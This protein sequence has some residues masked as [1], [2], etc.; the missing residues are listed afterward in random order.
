MAKK[1]FLRR[2]F[3]RFSTSNPQQWFVDWVSGGTGASAGI[4]I[5]EDKAMGY[6]PFWAAV[7]V[8]SGAIATLPLL[9]YRKTADG[10][11]R[12]EDHPVYRL[13]HD[14]PNP[15]MTAMTFIETRQAHALVYGNGYAEI[16]RDGAGRPVALWPL[17]PDKTTKKITT[18]KVKFP[19]YE[20]TLSD[21]STVQLPDYN[22]L[23]IP[24]LGF[25]GFTGYPVAQYHKEAIG[26]GMAT[27]KFGAAFFGNNAVPGGVLEMPGEITAEQAKLIQKQWDELHKGLEQSHRIAILEAGT[28]YKQMGV[29]PNDAQCLE[30]QKFSVDDVARIFCIPPHKIA[31]LERATFSNI[32][33]Q[34]LDFLTQ[35][36]VYWMRKWESE[37][38]NKLTLESEKGR[39]LA[40]FLPEVFLRG[41]TTSRYAAYAT[42]R[43]WGWLS[44]NDIRRLENL[45]SIGPDGDIYLEPLN[46]KPAGEPPPAPPE[47]P[48]PS[49]D[50]TGDEDEGDVAQNA[51]KIS[52]LTT[53]MTRLLR[54]EANAVSKLAKENG[55]L[56]AWYAVFETEIRRTLEK[57][58]SPLK[59]AELAQ[60]HVQNS[61]K[62]LENQPKEAIP[63]LVDAWDMTRASELLDHCLE[64]LHH[65]RANAK[66]NPRSSH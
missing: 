44:I 38:N 48:K 2:L 63:G 12:A 1:S 32:E 29:N 39:Y 53:A 54:R 24:G 61:Q 27:K 40:E 35:T 6:T 7:R 8:I 37:V 56:A 14:Q 19:Y 47:P 13:L 11:E 10:K 3:K 21:G 33:Q 4:A 42:A 57:L 62:L 20:V 5:T 55:D 60:K 64:D 22:V 59:A 65:A 15:F 52:L 30:T 36:L 49:P 16:E 66:R 45:N 43:Q 26:L 25:D 31:S 17:L 28:T 41:D 58:F 34:S 51:V 46:M 9:W 18:G 23:H 50:D